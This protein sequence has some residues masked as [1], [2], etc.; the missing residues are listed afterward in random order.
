[1]YALQD[2][3]EKAH[4]LPIL[5][6]AVAIAGALQCGILF[7]A[8]GQAIPA[9]SRPATLN[10][11]I[12][13]TPSKAPASQPEEPPPLP[14]P[15]PPAETPPAVEPAQ[16]P[17]LK[18]ET[19]IKPKPVKTKTAKR[20]KPKPPPLPPQ[21]EYL[22]GN[23]D[24]PMPEKPTPKV[25]GISA[26][27]TVESGSGPVMQVGN[28]Q[29]GEVSTVAQAPVTAAAT[30]VP[31]K[32]LEPAVEEVFEPAP[33]RKEAAALQM[34]K[35]QYTRAALR[36]GVEGKITL[37]VSIDETGQVTNVKLIKGIGF[38]LDEAAIEAVRTWK[39]SP[40]TLN[41]RVVASTKRER[42]SFVIEN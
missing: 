24:T 22:L 26:S 27:S 19:P 17:I 16:P 38:G 5:A 41:G 29:M 30:P 36:A 1:M 21:N 20:Q 28:T 23:D 31:P 8:P 14:N 9:K 37:L 33:V 18:Q 4:R 35:P 7:A 15:P 39:Y 2:E 10:F 34:T 11:S 25:A 3:P 13:Q 32:A 42:I 12:V 6:L 40:A